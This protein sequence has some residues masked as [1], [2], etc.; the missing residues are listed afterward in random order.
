MTPIAEKM[1]EAKAITPDK[2]GCCIELPDDDSKLHYLK[3]YYLSNP[4]ALCLLLAFPFL[5]FLD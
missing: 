3:Q 2:G 1:F 5:L 4:L